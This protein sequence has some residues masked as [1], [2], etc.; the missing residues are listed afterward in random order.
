MKGGPTILDLWLQKALD[1]EG[2]IMAKTTYKVTFTAA[3]KA[4]KVH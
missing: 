4:A 1:T 2:Q 3:E